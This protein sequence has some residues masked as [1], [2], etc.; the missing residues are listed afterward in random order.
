MQPICEERLVIAMPKDLKGAKE[1]SHLAL[2]YK[3]ILTGEYSREQEIE[4]LSI[5]NSIEF[6]KHTD[7][8]DT[9]YRMT[10]M[11]G[12]FKVAAC[13]IKNARHS[14]MH[15]NLMCA[16]IG[17]VITTDFAIRQKQH[18]A[19]DLLF[20]LP[21]SKESYRTIYIAKQHSADDNPIVKNFIQTVKVYLAS[22]KVFEK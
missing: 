14:E 19:K 3:E 17:A 21:K 11:L 18:N 12:D 5:F 7:R 20:F 9:A 2:T 4:D 8:T 13:E 22:Q 1:L 15:Y 16:G 6:I 10:N